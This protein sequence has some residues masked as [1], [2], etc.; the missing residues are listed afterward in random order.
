MGKLE[1]SYKQRKV[2]I[3]GH[4]GFKGSWLGLWLKIL[5]AEVSGYALKPYTQPNHFDLIGHNVFTH[6]F[7]ENIT[8]KSALS[9]ALKTIQPEIIFHLAAQPLVRQSY[10]EPLETFSTNALGTLT[11][12]DCI[13]EMQS[14]KAVVVVTTDKVYQ[15][16]P[17]ILNYR[18][19]DIL[20][21]KD[22]YSMS[23]ACTELLCSSMIQ[24]FFSLEQYG[25]TH[26]VLLATAR[27]GNVIGGGD[28][29]LDR[30]IPDVAKGANDSIST[31]IRNPYHIRPWQHVLESLRAYLMLGSSLLQ[32][33]KECASSFNFG[34]RIADHLSVQEVLTL[35]KKH[36]NKIQY[37]IQ[38]DTISPKETHALRLDS[39]K[40]HFALG[41]NPIWDINTAIKK[42]I[43]WYKSFYENNNIL[44]QENILEYMQVCKDQGVSL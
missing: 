28:W 40:S 5:G 13:R 14:V 23:K 26:N 12:L 24:S 3:T 21:G 32:G 29:S 34:P 17:N 10:Q 15:D 4:T 11:L 16:N 25:I 30:L 20:G 19:S 35:S 43:L 39:T 22:P 27:A 33:K 44:S 8:D 37:H 41:W 7:F 18:E 42:T 1:Q 36:W 9:R 31:P 38:S 2:F 6:S